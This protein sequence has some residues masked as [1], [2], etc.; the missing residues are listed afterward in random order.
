MSQQVMCNY[1]GMTANC[2]GC[3]HSKPHKP[4]EYPGER[5][6]RC[7]RFGECVDIGK[8]RRV[9]CVKINKEESK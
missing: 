1:A 2:P 6:K 8:V 9:R 5:C 3:P 4:F 7:T